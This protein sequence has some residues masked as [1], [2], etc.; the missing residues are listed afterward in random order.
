MGSDGN[1]MVIL[2][3]TREQ[4]PLS[5][6]DLPTRRATLVTGDYSV[7]A[8][9]RDLRDVVVIERKSVSDLL[10]CIGGQRRAKDSGSGASNRHQEPAGQS[11]DE[12][13]PF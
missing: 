9:G 13:I 8:N 10:G 5:F 1:G 4:R 6:G 2:V 12:D 7:I 11:S 3:D